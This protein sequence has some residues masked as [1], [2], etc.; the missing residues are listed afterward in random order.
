[1]NS[2]FYRPH[3]PATYAR[4]RDLTPPGFA[5]ALK[6]PKAATHESGLVDCEPVLDRFFGEIVALAEKAG[7]I[8]VQLPPGL[9]FD[10]AAAERFFDVMRRRWSGAIACEPRHPSWFADAAESLLVRRQVARVAADP[11]RHPRDGEPGGWP[12]LAYWRLH[13]SPRIY[14]SDY[15]AA[16]LEALADRLAASQAREAW[17]VFDNTAAGHAAA[18]ALELAGLLSRK[19][20]SP[21]R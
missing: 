20:W 7:P 6:L 19:C 2:T 12:E 21:A 8:L 16:A 5:F 10:Q 17:C 9:A 18:N 13:G 15:E 14:W 3:R 11:P 1:V 4:W